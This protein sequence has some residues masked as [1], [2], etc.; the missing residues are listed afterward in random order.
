M[1]QMVLITAA[2]TLFLPFG[3]VVPTFSIAA[4]MVGNGLANA[5]GQYLWTRA[6]H[7]APTSAVAPFHYFSL[8]WA[9]I[10]GFLVWGDVPTAHL[11]AGSGIVVGSG[12]FLLW[13][14]ARARR[15]KQPGA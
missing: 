10:L 14:E 11:L 7:L 12:L 6:L 9:M 5:L 3:F 2:F 15:K 4:V 8:V 1:Y 13:R